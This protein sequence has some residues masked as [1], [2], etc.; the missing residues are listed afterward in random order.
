MSPVGNTPEPS[1]VCVTDEPE[2][3]TV[4]FVESDSRRRA[5]YVD[6]SGDILSEQ[7]IRTSGHDVESVRV[8]GVLIQHLMCAGRALDSRAVAAVQSYARDL[9]IPARDYAD[10]DACRLVGVFAEDDGPTLE[11][12]RTVAWGLKHRLLYDLRSAPVS[13]SAVA[14]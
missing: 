3:V 8:V 13:S 6:L 14:P 7:G 5:Y 9:I 10:C 1:V 2:W 4:A 12:S 11:Q